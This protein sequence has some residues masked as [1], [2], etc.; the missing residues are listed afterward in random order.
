MQ[1]GVLDRGYGHRMQDMDPE[2]LATF[3]V[4]VMVLI[5][6]AGGL[7]F[8]LIYLIQCGRN[9]ARWDRERREKK[10]REQYEAERAHCEY[11]ADLADL[12]LTEADLECPD[13]D[14]AARLRAAVGL[15]RRVLEGLAGRSSTVGVSV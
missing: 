2:Q 1:P 13:V 7:V 5:A 14:V 4:L 9:E 3:L 6:G 15:H 11:V 10:A 12:G 8:Y